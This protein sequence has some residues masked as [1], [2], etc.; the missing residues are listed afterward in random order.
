MKKRCLAPS[1]TL[2]SWFRRFQIN[3]GEEK[4]PE[5]PAQ[6]SDLFFVET[7]ALG[8][9]PDEIGWSQYRFA[10]ASGERGWSHDIAFLRWISGRKQESNCLGVLQAQ[11]QPSGGCCRRRGVSICCGYKTHLKIYFYYKLLCIISSNRT[12]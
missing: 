4:S 3:F 1:S 11:I 7:M 12:L 2:Q 9:S 8:Y 10:L 6:Q 5:S